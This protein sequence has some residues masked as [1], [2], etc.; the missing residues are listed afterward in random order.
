MYNYV[1]Y[2]CL[3]N[4]IWMVPMVELSKI[5]DRFWQVDK[6]W[7]G[8]LYSQ[9]SQSSKHFVAFANCHTSQ[10]LKTVELPFLMYFQI[11]VTW[12]LKRKIIIFWEKKIAKLKDR[13]CLFTNFQTRFDWIYKWLGRKKI[14][15][16]KKNT[17]TISIY[18][19]WF[20]SLLFVKHLG[21]T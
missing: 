5:L 9:S 3:R 17:Y 13:N 12:N 2:R 20:F 14:Y 11:Y 4:I 21:Q 18:Y 8:L 16:L 15:Q 1:Q 6:S 19:N 10:F 7:I